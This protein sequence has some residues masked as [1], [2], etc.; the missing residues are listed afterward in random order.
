LQIRRTYER[1]VP[2]LYDAVLAETDSLLLSREQTAQLER[3]RDLYVGLV[4][5][6]WGEF[7]RQ[8]ANLGA[9]YDS[10]EAL[11]LQEAA[12]R[13]VTEIARQAALKLDNT[14]TAAQ[15]KL[16]PFPAGYLRVAKPGGILRLITN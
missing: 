2:N 12:A 13:S 16:L 1:T 9:Q 15:L 7:S 8:V 4:R 3:D 6:I 11:R 10:R 14:L 5:G